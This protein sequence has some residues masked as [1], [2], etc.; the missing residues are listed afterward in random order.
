RLLRDTDDATTA[1]PVVV[2]G[3]AFWQR[4]FA[5]SAA[6]IGTTIPLNGAPYVVVGVLPRH[7]PLPLRDLDVVVPLAPDRDPRRHLRNSVHFLRVVGRLDEGSTRD[8]AERELSVLTADLRT[9]FPTEYATKL[10]V[11]LTPLHEYLVGT[12]RLTLIVLL[13]GV[14]LLLAIAF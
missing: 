2:L 1:D 10:G 5:G 3:Y 6:V 4:N 8:I 7:F 14:G 11:R 13:G 12:S 9:Q